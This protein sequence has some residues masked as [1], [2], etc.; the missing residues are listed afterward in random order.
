M[1]V[2]DFDVSRPRLIRDGS[3]LENDWR[4]I[5]QRRRSHNRLG[6]AYP[7]AFVRV[8]G[9]FPQHEPLEID[10]EI[11]RFAALQLGADPDAIRDYAERRQTV[12]E[13]QRQIREYL[14]L[15]PFDA[16]AAEDLTRFLEDEAQ[17]LDRTSSLLARARGRLRDTQVLAPGES[18][19]R[20]A[21]GSARQAARITIAE[22]MQ[23][24]LSPS[25]R[26][27]LDTLLDTTDDDRF[28]ALNRIKESTPSPSAVGMRR[29]LSRLELIEMTGVLEIDIDWVNG[30]Y[31]RVLFHRA[32][33][34]R[35]PSA[36][37]GG[38]PA[39][40]GPR[41][42]PASGMARHAR[43]SGGHV[44][45]AARTQPQ[46]GAEPPGCE[47]EGAAPR[48]RPNRAAIRGMGVVL[49]DP[50]I[51]DTE[52]CARLFAV[53]SESELR[54]DH[55]DLAHW[56]RGDRKAR[57]EKMAERHAALS[58]FA[59]PFLARM[60]FLDEDGASTS[61]TLEALRAYRELR[62]AGASL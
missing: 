30:N 45:E 8:L 41:V 57:F 1:S 58:R 9:R 44:R 17:R 29:L 6:F 50:D 18:V 11:L 23:A 19:L 22:R 43:P 34:L 51:N 12:S 61:P 55:T 54:E 59:A 24:S 5:A 32:R 62:A 33:D 40:P 60:D 20:R 4:E 42:L 13:H 47:A 16:S 26:E 10:G 36:R 7:I 27:R 49:L 14:R 15:R 39:A 28:S 56:T 48:C 46:A 3:F 2:S 38:A 21:V 25:L 31:Q 35:G 52:L 53:V 37:D